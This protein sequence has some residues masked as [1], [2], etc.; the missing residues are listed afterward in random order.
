MSILNL[1]YLF[2]NIMKFSQQNYKNKSTFVR[3]INTQENCH[4]LTFR[5]HT[6]NCIIILSVKICKQ[7]FWEKNQ[8]N[9]SLQYKIISFPFIWNILNN[10]MSTMDS[11]SLTYSEAMCRA[12]LN[13]N[14]NALFSIYDETFNDIPLYRILLD[15]TNIQAS[16][17]YFHSFISSF[18]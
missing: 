14:C 8:Q 2:Q 16:K 7:S 15:C 3:K 5:E 4:F 6:H 9:I 18:S 1:I 12:C 10:Y 11:I 13:I 17:F